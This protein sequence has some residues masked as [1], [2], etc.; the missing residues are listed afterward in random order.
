[1]GYS[2]PA[3]LGVRAAFPDR[4]VVSVCGD[5]SFQMQ[6]M[7]LATMQQWK[8]PIKIV[9]MRNGYL[10]LVREYQHRTYSDRY[11]AVKLDGSP[12]FEKLA[13]AYGV[14]YFYLKDNAGMDKAVDAFL[15]WE[16]AALIVCEVYPFDSGKE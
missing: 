1:M 12:D 16:G 2:I 7:E 6:L 14:K 10:G 8:L 5:G 3:G 11:I 9:I 4:Q 15:A 13:D